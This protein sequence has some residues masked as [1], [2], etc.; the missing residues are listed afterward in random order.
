MLA[1]LLPGLRDLR[2]PLVVGYLWLVAIWLWCNDQLPQKAEARGAVADLYDLTEVLPAATALAALTFVAYFV[3]SLVELDISRLRWLDIVNPNRSAWEAVAERFRT[4]LDDIDGGMP[5]RFE[6]A[7][8]AWRRA[9]PART[10]ARVTLQAELT[11]VKEGLV[12]QGQQAGIPERGPSE[13]TENGSTEAESDRDRHDI[14]TSSY[15]S[16]SPGYRRHHFWRRVG[17]YRTVMEW[18]VRWI[19]FSDETLHRLPVTALAALY[20]LRDELPDLT[21]RLLIERPAVFD[22]YD[23]LLAEASI[24]VNMFPPLAALVATMAVHAHWLWWLGLVMCA[25]LL[26]QGILKR[27]RAIAVVLDSVATRLIESPT[28]QAIEAAIAEPTSASTPGT[29]RPSTPATGS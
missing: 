20:A 19:S 11:E 3:G 23:R 12:G 14:Q 7:V 5:G 17:A 10:T 22:Q 29:A 24:R 25:G 15:K 21:T 28:M 6:A 1:S 18:D 8:A 27:S 26:Y 4:R 16:S 13:I 9:A 2:I